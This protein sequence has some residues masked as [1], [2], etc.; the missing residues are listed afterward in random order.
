MALSSL[1]PVLYYIQMAR[2]SITGTA[3]IYDWA[4]K[5]SLNANHIIKM[6]IK[7]IEKRI[8]HDL[9]SLAVRI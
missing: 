8:G 3:S 2:P 5:P 6:S 9:V 4:V 7:L 1:V